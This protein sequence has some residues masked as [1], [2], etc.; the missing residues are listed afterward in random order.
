MTAFATHLL[1]SL[2]RPAT[3]TAPG[4]LAVSCRAIIKD[5]DREIRLSRS[6]DL[7]GSDAVASIDASL[8]PRRGGLLTIAG[9]EYEISGLVRSSAPGLV[10]LGLMRLSGAGVETFDFS[11]AVL[12]AMGEEITIEGRT[13][14]AQ[15]NRS[16]LLLEE[17][18]WGNGIETIRNVVAISKDDGEGVKAG[19]ILTFDGEDHR[20]LRVLRDGVSMLRI[21]C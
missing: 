10:D 21:V 19:T 2:G 16:G 3:Y 15:V 5:V 14:R 20:V 6:S 17:D 4:G 9:T 1:T 8:K 18:K 12:D 7:V 11:A 13:V